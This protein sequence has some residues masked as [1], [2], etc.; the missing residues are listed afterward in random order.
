[1]GRLSLLLLLVF[2]A[3][4]CSQ[5]KLVATSRQLD[6]W[7]ARQALLA[8]LENWKIQGR[9]GIYTEDEAWPGDLQWTQSRQQYDIRIIGSLG[10]GTLQVVSVEGGVVLRSSSDASPHFSPDPE[11]LLKSRFGWTLPIR[12][13]RFWMRGIPSPLESLTGQPELDHAGRVKSMEQSGWKISYNGYRKVAGF[14]L[15]VKILMEH[16]ELSVKVVI[17]KWQIR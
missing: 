10:A 7:K 16:K 1:M 11:S 9:V 5:Q 15:P 13:L 6:A 3:S 4:A 2:I 14:E 8:G 17:R 12:N